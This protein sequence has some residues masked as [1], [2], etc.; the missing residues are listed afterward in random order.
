M[1]NS[2]IIFRGKSEETGEWVLGYLYVLGE[3]TEYEEVYILGYLDHRESIHD[4]WKCAT[5]VDPKTVSQYI[6]ET[7][8]NKRRIFGGDIVHYVNPGYHE[9]EYYEV[10]YFYGQFY[11][12]INT[13][14][15]GYR[16]TMCEVVGN[17]WDNPEI[18]YV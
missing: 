6:G 12:G 9:H 17:I 13:P 10:K 18:D 11:I 4:I 3:G 15:G 7:D 8:K 14:I 16:A 1:I 2:S 5:K